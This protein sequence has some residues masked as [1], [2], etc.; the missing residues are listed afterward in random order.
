MTMSGLP[1]EE[2][3]TRFSLGELTHQLCEHQTEKKQAGQS[4]SDSAHLLNHDNRI[5]D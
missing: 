4:Q 5:I 2:G 1:P 3:H